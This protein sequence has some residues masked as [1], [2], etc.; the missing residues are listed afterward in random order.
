MPVKAR[1]Q[2]DLQPL[3]RARERAIV[4]LANN[5]A[6]I[7]WAMLR[8]RPKRKRDKRWSEIGS[9]VGDAFRAPFVLGDAKAMRALAADAGLRGASVLERVGEVLFPSIADL[10]ATERA[11]VWT[12]GGLL[13]D[14]Q[15][16]RLRTRRSESSSLS[17]WMAVSHSPCRH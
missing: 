3:N 12:L 16:A 5:L 6:R 2:S 10:V 14:E 15:F 9:G 4:A 8:G 11:C 1:S 17:S 7:A 13:D